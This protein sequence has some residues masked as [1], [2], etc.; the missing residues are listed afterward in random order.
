MNCIASVTFLTKWQWQF[1]SIGTS[2]VIPRCWRSCWC[3]RSISKRSSDKKYGNDVVS[4]NSNI[5][6]GFIVFAAGFIFPA[7]ELFAATPGDVGRIIVDLLMLRKKRL[8]TPYNTAEWVLKQGGFL[9]TPYEG[10]EV[11]VWYWWW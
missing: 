2:T 9:S 5:V 7:R 4:S 1:L 8:F 6:S 3:R 11:V 10:E